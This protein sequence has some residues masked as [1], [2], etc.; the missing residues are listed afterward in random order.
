MFSSSVVVGTKM[1]GV[2]RQSYI[3]SWHETLYQCVQLYVIKSLRSGLSFWDVEGPVL[4]V[5][6][7]LPA[8]VHEQAFFAFVLQTLIWIL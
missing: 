3:R 6:V 7:L 2:A 1:P 5:E 4:P 8:T